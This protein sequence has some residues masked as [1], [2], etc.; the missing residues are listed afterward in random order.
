[1]LNVRGA[2]WVECTCVT[3][4]MWSW[5]VCRSHYVSTVKLVGSAVGEWTLGTLSNWPLCYTSRD[6]TAFEHCSRLPLARLLVSSRQVTYWFCMPRKGKEK[7]QS[8]WMKCSLQP[9]WDIRWAFGDMILGICLF[10]KVTSVVHIMI[11]HVLVSTANTNYTLI[12]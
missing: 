4:C 11:K 10:S 3:Y 2:G 8:S 12:D 1:M 9:R 7:E 5:C 6:A